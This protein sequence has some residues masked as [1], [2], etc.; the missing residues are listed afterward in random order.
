MTTEPNR[1]WNY[2]VSVRSVSRGLPNPLP[3]CLGIKFGI[4]GG[5]ISEPK[6]FPNAVALNA[7]GRMVSTLLFQPQTTTPHKQRTPI[8]NLARG[9]LWVDSWS[10]VG[11]WPVKNGRSKPTEDRLKSDPPQDPDRCL[12]LRRGEGLWPK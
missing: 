11:Q 8:E 2:L 5:G 10:S 3:N 4:L 12:P 6:L 1:F 7:V 9:R